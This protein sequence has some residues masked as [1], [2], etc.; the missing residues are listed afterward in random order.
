MKSQTTAHPTLADCHTTR[1]A[2]SEM[3]AV[4]RC[5]CGTL[6]V[7]LGPMTL[8]IRAEGLRAIVETLGEALQSCQQVGA[9][10]ER[11]QAAL[12]FTSSKPVRGQS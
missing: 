4:D 8:R 6:S 5:S 7:H 11:R 1:L 2:E 9:T 3:V 12:A 10:G